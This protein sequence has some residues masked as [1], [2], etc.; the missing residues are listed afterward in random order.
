MRRP[1]GTSVLDVAGPALIKFSG[2]F[3]PPILVLLSGGGL[4]V[5][6]LMPTL[7]PSDV[8]RALAGRLD[9]ATVALGL[10]T[11]RKCTTGVERMMRLVT[12]FNHKEQ[13]PRR[14]MLSTGDRQVGLPVQSA[15]KHL[16]S[17]QP[18]HRSPALKVEQSCTTYTCILNWARPSA[19]EAVRSRRPL[20]HRFA[21]CSSWTTLHSHGPI[22]S[23]ALDMG[24]QLA[25]WAVDATPE[26]RDRFV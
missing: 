23:L 10:L 15:V 18:T 6:W 2:A 24:A 4:H 7:M 21:M 3:L 17:G 5:Y 13:V 26:S 1:Y 9:G 20:L 12:T 25:S 8:W 16:C 14:V 22:D 11:D 19:E